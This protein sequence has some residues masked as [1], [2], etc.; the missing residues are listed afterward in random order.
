M[1]KHFIAKANYDF[2]GLEDVEFAALDMR[3]KKDIGNLALSMG[4]AGR[5]HPAYL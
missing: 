1:G 3:I 5:S 2:R 4:V